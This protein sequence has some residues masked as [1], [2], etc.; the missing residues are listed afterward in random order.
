MKLTFLGADR[1]VTGSCHMLTA[2][3]LNILVDC[4]MEQGTDVYEN[5]ELP[6]PAS[7][8]DCVL[9]THAHVD[10][11]GLLPL[12]YKNGFRGTIWATS[13]TVDLCSVM[14][15]DSA[16]IQEFEAEWRNRKAKRNRDLDEFVPIYSMSDAEGAVSLFRGAAYNHPVAL[17]DAVS[18]RF[19]DAG[20]L[21]GSASVEITVT[22]EGKRRI[23]LFSGDIG[24]L[25]RPLINDPE[26][27]VTADYVV[28]ESTYGDRL[29]ERAADMKDPLKEAI[30]RT[31]SR[32]GNVI[33]PSFAVGRTQE[34]LYLLHGIKEEP[35]VPAFDVYVDSPLAVEATKIFA[36]N[37]AVYG[38]PEIQKYLSHGVNPID[39]PELHFCISSDDSKA[40]NTDMSPKVILSASGMCEAGRIRHHLKYN[41]WRPECAV[42]FVGYQASGTVGR[43]LLDGE[44]QIKLFGEQIDVRAEILN[45][46][47]LSG[48]ADRAGLL[49][50]IRALKNRPRKVF[51]VHGEDSVAEGFADTL[52]DED[53]LD[54]EAP[55]NGAEYDLLADTWL[56]AGNRQKHF[57]RTVKASAENTGSGNKNGSRY[58]PSSAYAALAAAVQ[59]LVRLTEGMKQWA[60]RDI[61]RITAQIESVC[62]TIRS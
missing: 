36:E 11:S 55:Y 3:G 41:L 13:V 14:L 49:A 37:L 59:E 60:N 35:G 1:E 32:G 40:L 20:H 29:H 2:A 22:E 23:L 19:L 31:V 38:D 21:L 34:L 26:Y 6:V 7:E 27:P 48:H 10:H 50:W 57:R 46:P 62:N 5:Q 30:V 43:R 18:V 12:L 9:L 17:S 51:V 53:A 61:R 4:G 44:K 58:A 39:F 15:R 24:S 56:S 52:R 28:M 8:V 54:A 25:G 47:G 16:H 42:L 45:L 33:I